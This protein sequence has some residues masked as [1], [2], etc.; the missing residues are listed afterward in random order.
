MRSQKIIF[1][2]LKI[3]KNDL[4][5]LFFLKK[6]GIS[7]IFSNSHYFFLFI[8]YFVL[9]LDIKNLI[10]IILIQIIFLD[11]PRVLLKSKNFFIFFKL[12]H[13]T[14]D[15]NTFKMYCKKIS[16]KNFLYLLIY[17]ILINIF[18]I[19]IDWNFFKFFNNYNYL[20]Y[21]ICILMVYFKGI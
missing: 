15:F 3:L 4:R 13:L 7:L 14:N 16:I 10:L 19:L 17:I 11:L 21:N 8:C 20:I 6:L 2:K 5:N 1:S 12:K 18:F 9:P